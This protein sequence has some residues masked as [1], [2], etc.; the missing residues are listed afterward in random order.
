MCFGVQEGLAEWVYQMG[1]FIHAVT[2]NTAQR[3]ELKLAEKGN[4]AEFDRVLHDSKYRGH[5]IQTFKKKPKKQK[6][7]TS[8]YKFL[9]SEIILRIVP[10]YLHVMVSFLIAQA[11]K[12]IRWKYGCMGIITL[13][14][15]SVWWHRFRSVQVITAPLYQSLLHSISRLVWVLLFSLSSSV[16][17]FR[18]CWGSLVHFSFIMLIQ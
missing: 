1:W 12:Q 3:L 18:Q 15:L 11:S 4:A 9:K 10:P 16:S 13:P 14:S 6:R 8:E 2:W 7:K 5:K 17:F